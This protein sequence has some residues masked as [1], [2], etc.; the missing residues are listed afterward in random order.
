MATYSLQD[1]RDEY[2]DDTACL[3]MIMQVRYGGREFTC[4]A[5]THASKF[6]PVSKRQAYACQRCGHH[7]YPCAGTT[8]ERSRTPLKDWFFALYMFTATSERMTAKTLQ[9]KIGC[10]YKTAWRMAR[11]LRKLT[12][13]DAE[14]TL[15]SDE[16][17]K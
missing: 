1:F 6:H 14:A 2:P 16:A 9:Q 10:T 3:D 15:P 13:G 4:P 8:F 11:A 5:C 7:I 17:L 12:V